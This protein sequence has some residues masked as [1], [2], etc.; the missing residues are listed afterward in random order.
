MSAVNFQSKAWL[1]HE[2]TAEGNA[3]IVVSRTELVR[4]EAR[5]GIWNKRDPGW[6]KSSRNL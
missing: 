6:K 1:R 5:C 4:C 3:K 2:R